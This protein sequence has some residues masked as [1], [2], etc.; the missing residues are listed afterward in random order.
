MISA[1]RLPSFLNS[2]CGRAG[3]FQVRRIT[4]EPSQAGIGACDGGSNGLVYFMR[5]RTGQLTKHGH[6]VHVR[7]LR[8]Q[9]AQ[10]LTLFL[11][12][13]ALRHIDVGS[14]YFNHFS[15]RT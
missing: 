7:K 10:P 14:H 8:L 15:A 6:S 4:C 2:Y 11:G 3:S 1:A 5:K 12:A 13:L 9:L